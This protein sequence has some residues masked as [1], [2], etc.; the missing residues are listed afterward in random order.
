MTEAKTPYVDIHKVAEY[1]IVSVATI[2]KWVRSGHIPASTY[3]KVG[4]VYRF[5]IPDIEA[6]L[7]AATK[8]AQLGTLA[9][10]NGE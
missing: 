5:R 4:E 8:K 7:T 2:R 6:A 3:L 1:F 10:K 9:R